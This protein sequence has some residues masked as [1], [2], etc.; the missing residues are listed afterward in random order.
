MAFGENINGAQRMNPTAAFS[1]KRIIKRLSHDGHHAVEL[2]E[3]SV[4]HL[5][6]KMTTARGGVAR[7]LRHFFS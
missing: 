4:T 7:L 6:P 5:I 3:A 1:L 2:P